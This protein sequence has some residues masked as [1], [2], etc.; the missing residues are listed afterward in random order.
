ME[1]ICFKRYR[2]LKKKKINFS[3]EKTR[4]N[5]F[6]FV[7]SFHCYRVGSSF[8]FCFE[9]FFFFLV[10]IFVLLCFVLSFTMPEPH[11]KGNPILWNGCQRSIHQTHIML[12]I[13]RKEKAEHTHHLPILQIPLQKLS[14]CIDLRA[15]SH[16]HNQLKR[17]WDI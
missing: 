16:N 10:G 6:R 11:S 3:C 13:K 15:Q 4:S 5:Q 7:M 2:Y 17:W 1:E 12:T 9:G 14:N 8:L